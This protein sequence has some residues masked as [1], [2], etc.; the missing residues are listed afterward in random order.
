MPDINGNNV[1]ELAQTNFQALMSAQI[2]IGA[3]PILLIYPFLQRFFAAG[4]VI[5]AV[6]E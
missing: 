6:K 3:L 1:K 4:I 5:G 2:V